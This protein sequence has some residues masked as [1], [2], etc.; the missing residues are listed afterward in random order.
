MGVERLDNSVFDFR[1]SNLK[2][3]GGCLVSR[4][5]DPAHGTVS[6]DGIWSISSQHILL[7]TISTYWIYE[8]SEYLENSG[9]NDRTKRN[10]S[11]DQPRSHRATTSASNDG[12]Y[13]QFSPS[14]STGLRPP[15][16]SQSTSRKATF[17]AM[18]ERKIYGIACI[19]TATIQLLIVVGSLSITRSRYAVAAVVKGCPCL[20]KDPG[21]TGN[22]FG[23][24]YL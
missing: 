12:L 2:C 20:W 19:I 24:T 17:N 1:G 7:Y 21:G 5:T 8:R 23:G 16:H 14:T 6:T 10:Q 13:S 22:S 9:V 18:E 4:G 15:E 11:N 3:R